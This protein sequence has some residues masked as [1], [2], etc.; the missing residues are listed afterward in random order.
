[1]DLGG[2]EFFY[3]V[4]DGVKL[5]GRDYG[6]RNSK[7]HPVV[8]LPGL[9]R[10][11]RDFDALAHYLSSRENNPRRVIAFDYRGRGKSDHAA[12]TTYTPQT[13][14]NDVLAGMSARGISEAD[15][16]GTSRGGLLCMAIG[17]IRP[18]VLHN[19][20]LN[21]I[22][23]VIHV[24][25]LAAIKGYVAGNATPQSWEV[26]A[27]GLKALF[28]K[29]FMAMNSDDWVRIARQMYDEVNGRPARAFDTALA[30]GLKAVTEASPPIAIWPQFATLA[31][32][33]VLA[34]RGANSPLLDQETFH[35][36]GRSHRDLEMY[37]VPDQGHAPLLWD[38]ETQNRIVRFLDCRA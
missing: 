6:P 13:E 12:A 19:V 28:S 29:T 7:H 24:S 21:D 36:M 16:I 18:G 4:S 31:N 26:A 5:S 27:K 35:A 23:P 32:V 2:S 10:N 8:C 34:L 38:A 11:V 20:V 37:I 25:Y 14:A 30:A 33:P 9:T 3:R 15:F 22:G 17:A 1:M